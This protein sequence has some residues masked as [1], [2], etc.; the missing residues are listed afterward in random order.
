MEIIRF[1]NVKFKYNAGMIDEVRAVDGINLSI[2]EGEF[3][4]LVGHNGSGKSTLAKL[5][6]GLEI[7]SSGNVFVS[8][9][10][11]NEERKLTASEKVEMV[12]LTPLL[13]AG[14]EIPLLNTKVRKNLF[15]IRKTVGVVF[16][17]PDNQ[18]VATIIEDD[19]AF[20]PENLGL[21]PKEIRER[22]EWALKSVG[23]YGFKDGAP[24]RLSGGQKQRI[25]IAG[26]LAIKPKVIVLDEATSM[27]DPSGRAEVLDVIK[28]L[29]QEEGMT[30]VMITHFMEEA[31][32]CDRVV[33]LKEGKVLLDGGR[34]IFKEADKIRD[35]GLELPIAARVAEGLRTKGVDLSDGIVDI[36]E[37]VGEL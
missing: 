16:Q 23:M 4:A 3:L 5:M 36:E 24:Y 20:G 9:L 11:V 25:A 19:I 2:K 10:D 12:M 7:P 1:D 13:A 28:R 22:V 18:M 29:N 15:D 35:A 17:N 34:E 33:V 31:A 21:K 27:L 32:M 37:L 8:G 30:V 14:G 26:V 6:N